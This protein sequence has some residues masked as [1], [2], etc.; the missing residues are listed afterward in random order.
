MSKEIKKC[1]DCEYSLP[2]LTCLFNIW[3]FA[4]CT[5]TQSIKDEESTRPDYH[6]G[7][8]KPSRVLRKCNYCAFMREPSP[9]GKCT[10]EAIY[11]KKERR[12]FFKKMKETI[13]GRIKY[14]GD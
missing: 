3:D 5:H 2:V 9:Y 8:D 13:F 1:A 11:F 6:L 12:S 14:I 10:P 4:I 7:K